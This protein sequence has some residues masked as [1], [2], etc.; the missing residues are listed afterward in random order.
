MQYIVPL[1]FTS[2]P[3]KG[4]LNSLNDLSRGMNVTDDKLVV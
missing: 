3:K 1:D 2:V 4:H